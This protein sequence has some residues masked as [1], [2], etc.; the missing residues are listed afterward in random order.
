M[1]TISRATTLDLGPNR[2]LDLPEHCITTGAL[3]ALANKMKALEGFHTSS[4]GQAEDLPCLVAVEVEDGHVFAIVKSGAVSHRL[5][6]VSGS[7]LFA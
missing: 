6:Y 1:M 2:K 5:E 3:Y 4:G 7:W